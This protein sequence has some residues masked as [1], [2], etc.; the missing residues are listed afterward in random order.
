MPTPL[1]EAFVRVSVDR[2]A[3]HKGLLT[4][5]ST[6]IKSVTTTGRLAARAMSRVFNMRNALFGGLIGGYSL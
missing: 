1:A 6:I 4:A 3:L 5:R 2:T